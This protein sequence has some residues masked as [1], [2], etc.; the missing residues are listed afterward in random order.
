MASPWDE[1]DG[2][3]APALD[4]T[5]QRLALVGPAEVMTTLVRGALRN[6]ADALGE[7]ARR[8]TSATREGRGDEASRAEQPAFPSTGGERLRA[9]AAAARAFTDTY[10]DLAVPQGYRFDSEYTPT[11]FAELE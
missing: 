4:H 9:I 1:P 10:V 8:P 11:G 7:A 3:S 5:G 6:V 2:E